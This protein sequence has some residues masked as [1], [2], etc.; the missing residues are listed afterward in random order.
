M[1]SRLG[2]R[3]LDIFVLVHYFGNV[4]GQGEANAF[5]QDKGAL[6][7]EDCA[8]VIGYKNIEWFGDFLLFSPHKLFAIP[9]IGCLIGRV[10]NNHHLR[11]TTSKRNLPIR[12]ML[13]QIIKS[14]IKPSLPKWKDFFGTAISESVNSITSN[15][16]IIK[17]AIEAFELS[18]ESLLIRNQNARLL[19]QKLNKVKNWSLFGSNSAIDSSYVL[20]MICD[21][22][23]I[24]KRRFN[25]LNQNY[26]L[27]MQWPDLP[28][29]I[30]QDS[31]ILDQAEK[32]QGLVLFFFIHQ[33][34][35]TSIWARELDKVV[36]ASNF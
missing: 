2:N 10:N 21:S 31:E 12:W 30:S 7:I 27:V 5:S 23:E 4:I 28:L 11:T 19:I 24:A 14:G 18:Q 8:H 32:W 25:L 13:K 6:F 36:E 35:D 15:S 20:G 29:E 22:K 17:K 34:L 33:Q 1:E 3:K 16:F 9:S 26:Q